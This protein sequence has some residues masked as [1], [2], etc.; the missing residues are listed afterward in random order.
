MQYHLDFAVMRNRWSP[1]F[2]LYCD[3]P[4][5]K[6]VFLHRS[7]LTIPAI[8]EYLSSIHE[9]GVTGRT[10]I[11]NQGCVRCIRCPFPVDDIAIVLGNQPELFEPLLP[12]RAVRAFEYENVYST[13]LIQ[14]S[15]RFIDLFD[16][17]LSVTVSASQ[18]VFER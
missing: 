17:V 13:E 11:A 9:K 2:F 5:P 1:V 14:A 7:R 10:E 6:V 16:P 4:N 18:G 8:C 3:F 15:F 12:F